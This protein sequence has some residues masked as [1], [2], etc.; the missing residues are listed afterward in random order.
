MSKPAHVTPVRVLSWPHP[1]GQIAVVVLQDVWGKD[2]NC[3]GVMGL[4]S[5]GTWSEMRPEA[6]S[7]SDTITAFI[8]DEDRARLKVWLGA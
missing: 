7:W 1:N 5:D 2:G 8:P 4:R 3:R 6:S